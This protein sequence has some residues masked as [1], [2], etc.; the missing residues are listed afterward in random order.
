[1]NQ[2]L[3]KEEYK[4]KI[5]QVFS[6]TDIAKRRSLFL[7]FSRKNFKKY[8]HGNQ[9]D[10]ST[11]DDL[12]NTKNVKQSFGMT[13]CEDCAYCD[14]MNHSKNCYDVSSFGENA[15]WIYETST[16]GL[17]VNNCLFGQMNV[18]N[19]SNLI[20]CDMIQSSKD[21]FGCI[22]I[23]KGS[24]CIMNIPYSAHEYEELCGKIIAHMQN[25]GEW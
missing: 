16:A 10:N 21:C 15:S 22:S 2:Q 6:D 17:N 11:G 19:S 1:M 13:E 18:N 23:K 12:Y 20:Y 5:E 4:T 24:H 3:S 25:T 9:I 7:D 14:L 8:V